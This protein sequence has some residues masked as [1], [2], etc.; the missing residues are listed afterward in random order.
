MTNLRKFVNEGSS[1]A[2]EGVG[3]DSH[4][5]KRKREDRLGEEKCYEISEE[6]ESAIKTFVDAQQPH[7]DMA[8]ALNYLLNSEAPTTTPFP[9]T[10]IL[11][12]VNLA[13]KAICKVTMESESNVVFPAEFFTSAANLVE[14]KT[15]HV[16]VQN[17]PGVKFDLGTGYSGLFFSM[18]MNRWRL[19]NV[20]HDTIHYFDPTGKKGESEVAPMAKIIVGFDSKCRREAQLSPIS[21]YYVD[22]FL[23]DGWKEQ[24]NSFDDSI[25]CL[26]VLWFKRKNKRLPTGEDL[27]VRDRDAMRKV[28]KFLVFLIADSNREYSYEDLKK[29][30]SEDEP[31]RSI[32]LDYFS[33]KKWNNMIEAFPKDV[34]D[35]SHECVVAFY[36]TLL[37]TVKTSYD[38]TEHHYTYEHFKLWVIKDLTNRG[39]LFE[40]IKDKSDWMWGG[41]HDKAQGPEEYYETLLETVMQM[42]N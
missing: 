38:T 39:V 19:L 1:S 13:T 33:K 27:D 14:A 9:F 12:A 16:A 8:A 41:T 5:H 35:T 40:H 17:L 34:E 18:N 15:G 23:G 6:E 10:V 22:D 30:V 20:N 2:N 28:R 26:F 24:N 4:H 36:T 42:A 21:D 7:Q 29:W 11:F 31:S 25:I 37:D 3:G 32:L